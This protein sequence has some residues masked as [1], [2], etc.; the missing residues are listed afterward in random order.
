M[1]AQEHYN[2]LTTQQ[3]RQ[4]LRSIGATRQ[5]A[6]AL[7]TRSWVAL[8]RWAKRKLK[9]QFDEERK[10]RNCGC[11]ASTD[12]T[13]HISRGTGRLDDNGFWEFPCPHGNNGVEYVG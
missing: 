6:R 11:L 9:R 5:V 2:S 1:N 8:S 3:S 13:G 12:I 10:K 7:S 4:R